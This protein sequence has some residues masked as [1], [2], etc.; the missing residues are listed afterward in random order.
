MVR[1]AREI[2]FVARVQAQADRTEM[3]FESAAWIEDRAGV[4]R[5]QI[6]HG[7]GKRADG[8]GAIV[9]EEIH[10]AAF[11]RDEG[12]KASMAEFELWTEQAVESADIGAR[13]ADRRWNRGIVCESF[14]ENL[15]EVVAHFAFGLNCLYA[16]KVRRPPRPAKS[17]L[18]WD[19]RK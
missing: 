1:A 9:K 19:N 5:A 18:V 15:V 10:K 13:D 4:T 6:I 7:A 14:G 11:H 2:D 3:A 12:M 17:V 8:C 16:G